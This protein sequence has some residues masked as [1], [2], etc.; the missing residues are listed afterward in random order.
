M[1]PRSAL[2][3]ISYTVD[4]ASED[5]MSRDT[6]PT[7][8]SNT[9]NKA[10]GRK[11]RGRAA[12][13]TKSAP[14][15]KA[16]KAGAKAKTAT[17]RLSPGTG[18]GVK[19]P[20]AKKAAGGRPR[21]ALVEIKNE[22]ASDT[23]EVDEFDAE[24]EDEI[25]AAEPVKAAKPAR[26]GRQAKNVQPEEDEMEV[27]APT[28]APAKR[29]R[30][31]AA[32]TASVET[33]LAPKAKAGGRPKKGKRAAEP[34]YSTIPETQPV[35]DPMEVDED[36]EG[37]IEVEVEEE[38]VEIMAP[39]PRANAS[40]NQPQARTVRQTPTSVRRPR[41][42]SVS[43]TPGL[44]RKVGEITQK[45]EAMTAKY[46]N[47]KEVA[48]S[49]RESNFDALRKQT[50][51]A[52]RNQDAV[53]KSLQQQIATMQARSAEIAGLKKELARVNK[54]NAKLAEEKEDLV[55]DLEK[56]Q[57]ENKTLTTKLAAVRAAAP[58]EPKNV[59]GSAVKPRA[60]GVVLP[61]AAEAAKEAQINRQKID[62]YSDLTNLV[63]IGV[64]KG[65]SGE[66][67][68]D[69][70]QTGRN[71]SKWIISLKTLPIL[72]NPQPCTS[73]SPSQMMEMITTTSSSATRPYS[74]R[75]GTPICST[76]CRIT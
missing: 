25:T 55:V 27:E 23:E 57:K 47:L 72:T 29:G 13:A 71:G 65:E 10:P 49:A 1:A 3:N 44:R 12:Q 31:A 16:I 66:D 18:A 43:E 33:K 20:G 11:P 64:K 6:F 37:S 50:E 59:P 26:R 39:P 38:A 4:S 67:V 63:I 19:K 42:G 75:N 45:L 69:C 41:A 34:D 21:K 61:G 32:A 74:T 17:R 28:P 53:I 56:S 30:K 68:Y 22:D 24:D 70:L 76:C 14:E 7:P 46:E 36:V 8:D 52:A 48:T 2:A 62:L 15:T 60:P 40:R 58:T 54:E 35:L 51:A 9:E 5:E 73:N